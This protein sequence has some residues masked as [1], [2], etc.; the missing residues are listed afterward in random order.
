M[1]AASED[2][3]KIEGPIN[4]GRHGRPF[5][6]FLGDLA[7]VG[8]VEEEYFL[9]GEATAYAPIGEL[10]TNG[11]WEVVESDTAPFVTRMLVRRPADP[12]R[13]NGIVVAE[14]I[15]VTSGFEAI[16]AQVDLEFEEGFAHV[17]ISAQAVGLDGFAQHPQGLKAWDPERYGKLI[18]PGD[19]HSYDIFAHGV[20]AVGPN[21]DRD[22]IDPMGGLDVRRVIAVG[23]SQS[24]GRLVTY[25]NAV[26]PQGHELDGIL[27]TLFVGGAYTFTDIPVD[28][29][30]LLTAT[31]EEL[32][33][34][35]G[36]PTGLR[37]DRDLPFF[38]INTEC[39]S[40]TYAG[41]RQEDSER[42]HYWEIAGAAHAPAPI[43]ADMAESA[44]R[45]FGG[46]AVGEGLVD[47][48]LT[49]N[50]IDWRP[51]QEAALTRLVEWIETGA[52]PP[53]QEP[54]RITADGA[55]RDADGNVL[56]GLRMPELDAP[57][58][59]YDGGGVVPGSIGLSGQTTYFDAARLRDRYGDSAGH[60]AA[61]SAAVDRA[62]A[63]GVLLPKHREGY[64][65]AA[66][67]VTVG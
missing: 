5:G 43:M 18:H 57:I 67:S 33:A 19:S 54:I 63:A 56:G 22:G 29:S 17:G 44:V 39:E 11:R 51:V 1:D 41:V 66:R 9:S 24:A 48:R 59:A 60:V 52:R 25:A 42:F 23:S 3:D 6:A 7:E 12:A 21:R 15:N 28:A 53:A 32:A 45:D 65:V 37:T 47:S 8:Y 62:I 55:Q 34:I 13:F 36:S 61:V 27:A 16:A 26:A 2:R 58:A 35:L 38:L 49:P 20:H 14:W 4:G 46:F 40:A 10:G 50:A 64:L 30:N 31:P